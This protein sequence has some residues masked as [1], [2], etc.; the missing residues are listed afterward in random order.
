MD[1]GPFDRDRLTLSPVYSSPSP[2]GAV[3]AVTALCYLFAGVCALLALLVLAFWGTLSNAVPAVR[4]W[5]VFALFAG[6]A[7]FYAIGGYQV[8]RRSR[9]WRTVLVVFFAL[10]IVSDVPFIFG[11]PSLLGG[12]A[13]AALLIYLLAGAQSSRDY[14]ARAPDA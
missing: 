6:G 4:I 9:I 1:R 8:R 5:L 2:P 12:I 14:F 3:T 7:V 10:A 11:E 13:V